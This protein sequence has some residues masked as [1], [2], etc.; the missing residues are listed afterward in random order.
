MKSFL[1]FLFALL[2]L[3]GSAKA[4]SPVAQYDVV[5]NQRIDASNSPFNFGVVAFSKETVDSISCAV[6]SGTATYTGSTPKTDTTMELNSRTDVWE[7]FI[8]ISNTDFSSS[9]T[10]TVNCTVTDGVSTDRTI[11]AITLNV[12]HNGSGLVQDEAW[13]NIDVNDGTGTLNDDT[14]P[15]PSIASAI[16]AIEAANS[17][18]SGG[19]VIYLVEDTYSI[20]SLTPTTT[21]EWLTLTAA[22]GAAKENVIINAGY[23]TTD[24]LKVDGITLQSTGTGQ[25]ILKDDGNN[26]TYGWINNCEQIGSGKHVSLGNPVHWGMTGKYSTNN[27]I[28]DSSMGVGW[29]PF[30]RNDNIEAIGVDVYFNT[31]LVINSTITDHGPGVTSAHSDIYQVST[32]AIVVNPNYYPPENRIIYGLKATDAHNQ[33]FFSTFEVDNGDDTANDNALVNVMIEMRDPYEN[34]TDFTPFILG[35][36]NWDHLI[37]WNCTFP[38]G[39]SALGSNIVLTNSSFVGNVFWQLL[40]TVDVAPGAAS[41][42]WLYNHYMYVDGVTAD[43]TPSS[44]DVAEGKDCP[45]TVSSMPDSGSDATTGDPGIV[46]N[47]TPA[48]SSSSSP[49]VTNSFTSIV[50]SDILN[51]ERGLISNAG[52]YE[53]IQTS[54]SIGKPSLIYGTIQ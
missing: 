43:C 26:P 17:G 48:P 31:A 21:N 1:V 2:L 28:H 53:Y 42:D 4:F 15:Y 50:P 39:V 13:V 11:G 6:A 16:T 40:E 9:G 38:Y 18:E 45:R 7:Y 24:Y 20:S 36:D 5:P 14:D 10:F 32:S 49:L 30:S 25:S 12:D 37:M 34:T 27:Y 19:G 41:N 3:P 47:S 46:S 52:A 51:T 22:S 54:R 29:G 33:G 44:A 8:Q 23:M 35:G